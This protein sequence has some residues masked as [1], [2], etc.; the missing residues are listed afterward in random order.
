MKLEKE[1]KKILPDYPNDYVITRF[2]ISVSI[3]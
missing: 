1:K 2:M 3:F